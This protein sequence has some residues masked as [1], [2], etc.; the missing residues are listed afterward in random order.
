MTYLL[1][2]LV[3]E[4]LLSIVLLVLV[5]LDGERGGPR[6]EVGGLAIVGLR[7]DSVR[8]DQVLEP[9]VVDVVI[10]R[11]ELD[12]MRKRWRRAPAAGT[13]ARVRGVR[14]PL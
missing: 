11:T 13:R 2:Q 3:V 6:A 10:L 9:L 8:F 12:G 4:P 1:L 14:P 7:L 5:P